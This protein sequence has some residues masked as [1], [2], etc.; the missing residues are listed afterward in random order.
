MINIYKL[1]L[2]I[3]Q[4]SIMRLLFMK[5]GESFNARRIAQALDVSQPAISKALP[6][7]EKQGYLKVVKDKESKRLA[8][9]LN[10]ESSLVV[11]LKRAENL[12]QVYETG[13]WQFL[14]ESFPG[15]TI[16]LFG[17][18][19]SGEDTATSD[20]DI[21]VV[22]VAE[23]T[24]ELEQFNKALGKEISLHYFPS[25]RKIH[26]NLLNNILSG[27]TLKGAISLDKI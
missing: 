20:I 12:R 18:Y 21:A 14:Y 16:I 23:K 19:A 17:S 9:E 8:I 27:I 15:A 22:G 7:L 6:L 10:R 24:L 26:K 11:G 3:L 5:A 1:K 13:L 25:F 2:T 4:L